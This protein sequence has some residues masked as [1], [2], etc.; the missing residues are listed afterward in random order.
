VATVIGF[1]MSKKR[2]LNR[3]NHPNLV[4]AHDRSLSKEES[5]AVLAVMRMEQEACAMF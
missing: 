4:F 3:E 5:S 1:C 2:K